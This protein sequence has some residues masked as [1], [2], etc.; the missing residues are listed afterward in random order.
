VKKTWAPGGILV[1]GHHLRKKAPE[2][3]AGKYSDAKKINAKKKPGEAEKGRKRVKKG[4]LSQTN[5][6]APSRMNRGEMLKQSGKKMPGKTLGSQ[7]HKH[8]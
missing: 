7:R 5:G 4:T 1:V 8:T 6:G 2:K 3:T